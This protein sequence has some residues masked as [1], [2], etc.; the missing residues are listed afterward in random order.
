MTSE[1]AFVRESSIIDALGLEN[2]TNKI[3]GALLSAKESKFPPEW[4]QANVN[5]LGSRLLI[6]ESEHFKMFDPTTLDKLFEHDL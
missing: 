5:N 3:R 6:E 2:L 4:T 1:E